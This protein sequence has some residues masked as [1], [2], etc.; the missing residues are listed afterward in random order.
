MLFG[1]QNSLNLTLSNTQKKKIKE[2]YVLN[3][4]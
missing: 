2:N 3:A 1:F 4:L